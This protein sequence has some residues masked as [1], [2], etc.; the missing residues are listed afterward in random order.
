[1]RTDLALRLLARRFVLLN[2]RLSALLVA[3]HLGAQTLETRKRLFR[4]L[5]LGG[6]ARK[7]ALASGDL[8]AQARGGAQQ[9]RLPGETLLRL[10]AQL[11]RFLLLRKRERFLFLRHALHFAAA[12][13]DGLALGIQCFQPFAQRGKQQIIVIFV[14]L[15]LEHG[16]LRRALLALCDLQLVARFGKLALGVLGGLGGEVEL[17]G[18]AAAPR[19]Q[20]AQLAGSAQNACAAGDRAARHRAAA[21]QDLTVERHDAERIRKLT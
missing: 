10:R 1:M 3:L 5:A 18:K 8:I 6:K 4:C 15:Q 17:F 9:L 11:A 16:V 13:R 20:L 12:A 2:E 21:V 7:R 19:R 14:A